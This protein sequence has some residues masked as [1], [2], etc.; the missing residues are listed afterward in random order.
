VNMW[1][2]KVK[3]H[4]GGLIQVTEFS[5]GIPPGEIELRGADDGT[6]VT[7]NARQRDAHGRFVVSAHHTRDRAEEALERAEDIA[8]A[9]TEA[10]GEAALEVGVTGE[11]PGA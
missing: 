9:V 6:R 7:L 10:G 2:L 8:E 1:S 3:V 4:P 5:D 11:V